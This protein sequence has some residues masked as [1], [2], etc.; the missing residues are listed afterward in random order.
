MAQHAQGKPQQAADLSAH[1]VGELLVGHGAGVAPLEP[2]L[3]ARPVIC[4][5]HPPSH[6]Q[7]GAVFCSDHSTQRSAWVP[8]EF[9]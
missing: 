1:L 6:G 9:K 2:V 8:E 4:A 7:P 5:A 3:N